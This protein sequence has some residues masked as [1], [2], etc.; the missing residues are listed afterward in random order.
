MTGRTSLR[1]QQHAAAS[2]IQTTYTLKPLGYQS[3]FEVGILAG[4]FPHFDPT[5][6]LESYSP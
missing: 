3:N 1:L 4:S 6:H 5:Y 2:T